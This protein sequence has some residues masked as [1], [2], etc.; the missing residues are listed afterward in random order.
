[1]YNSLTFTHFTKKEGL[2]NNNV[3]SILEDS[4]GNL[5]FGNWGAGVTRYDGDTFTHF[6]DRDALSNNYVRSILEDSQGNLWFGTYGGGVS[7]LRGDT[8]THFT[9]NEGL[10]NNVVLSILE[11]RYGKLWFGT[12]GGGVSMYEGETITYFTEKEGLS[13]NIVQSLKEDNNGNIWIST[14]M[15]LNLLEFDH[16]SINGEK[17]SPLIRNYGLQ[18]GLKG[19]DFI[20]N[21]VLLDSNNRLWWGNS[22]SLA[23]LDMNNFVIP[24]D[25]PRIQLN[26][27]EINEQ[28]ADFKNLNESE[29][30]ELDFDSV[31]EFYNY[32]LNLELPYKSNHMNFHYAAID[33]SAPHKIRYSFR[34]EGLNDEWSIPSYE[35]IADYRKLPHGS[36][37]FMVR[38]IG[39][40]QKWSEA[41]E[42]SFTIN[43]PWW[44]TWWAKVAYS[45]VGL[46]IVFG[47]VRWRTVKLTRHRKELES[48][49]AQATLRIREQKE[50]I[51]TQRDEVVAT[52]A[53]LGKQKRE[54]EFTLKNLK[55]TQSQ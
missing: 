26:N 53:A 21:S 11:D 45:I 8:I 49:V 2:S 41:F 15:G 14:E 3:R 39:G 16:D 13:N 51:E 4:Q 54:L 18:D 36:Y 23:M 47:F 32:P 28:F 9:E 50:E 37:T 20:L 1:M 6:S 22:R 46:L 42:Y 29:V 10:S 33:W 31:A 55:M 34:M 35:T 19:M 30:W 27:I 44:N 25:P 43:P 7:M 12:Y 17:S 40:A 38:A 48:E 24:V 5:W 52:N